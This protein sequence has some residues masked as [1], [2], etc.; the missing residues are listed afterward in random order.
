MIITFDNLAF[1]FNPIPVTVSSYNG[2]VRLISGNAIIQK[3]GYNNEPIYFD[4]QSVAQSLFD[5]KEFSNID[6]KDNVLFKKIDFKVVDNT[7]ENYG[8]IDVIYGALQIGERFVRTKTLTFFKNMP[9]TFPLFLKNGRNF[10]WSIDGNTPAPYDNFESG[11]H[12]VKVRPVLANN[13]IVFHTDTFTEVPPEIFLNPDNL[14]F[15]SDTVVPPEIFLQ[16]ND[17][18]F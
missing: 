8:Q 15:G 4:L 1:A 5:R 14:I 6:E 16:P 7:S 17:L 11:K 13:K 9:F 2:Y 3:E 12:N 10:M 18:N